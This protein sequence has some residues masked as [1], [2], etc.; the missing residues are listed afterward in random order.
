MN[1]RKV[2]TSIRVLST[3]FRTSAKT[4]GKLDEHTNHQYCCARFTDLFPYRLQYMP[5]FRSVCVHFRKHINYGNFP[6]VLLLC[7]CLRKC[8]IPDSAYAKN[9]MQLFE[10]S[11]DMCAC[12]Y[13]YVYAMYIVYIVYARQSGRIG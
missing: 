4:C 5:F 10:D 1:K 2:H 6:D 9:V 13:V 12:V 7:F 8:F 3:F 11:A